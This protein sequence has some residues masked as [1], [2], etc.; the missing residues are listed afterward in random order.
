VRVKFGSCHS[1]GRAVGCVAMACAKCAGQSEDD[2][3]KKCEGLANMF[4]QLFHVL[5]YFKVQVVPKPSTCPR[6]KSMLLECHPLDD[7]IVRGP[8]TANVCV[9]DVAGIGGQMKEERLICPTTPKLSH[10]TNVV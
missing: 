7:Q 10:V 3:S 2:S 6:E 1:F 8:I 5:K 9:C 4:Y